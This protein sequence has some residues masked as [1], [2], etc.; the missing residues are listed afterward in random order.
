AFSVGKLAQ[1]QR[2]YFRRRIDEQL[3]GIDGSDC[4]SSSHDGF[5]YSS[6][7]R[8]IQERLR[9]QVPLPAQLPWLDQDCVLQTRPQVCRF[10]RCRRRRCLAFRLRHSPYPEGRSAE[11]PRHRH[12]LRQGGDPR[13]G[14]P[15]LNGLVDSGWQ[16]P[17][18]H[19]CRRL[20]VC[21]LC[22][23]YSQRSILSRS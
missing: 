23:R 14:Q 16:N 22:I 4:H 21:S 17:V 18:Q 13:L 12:L 1:Q 3:K 9:P 5:S 6:P 19:P 7:R 20:R 2:H 10:R 15:L 11:H 8:G